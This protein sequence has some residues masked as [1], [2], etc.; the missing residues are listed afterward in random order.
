EKQLKLIDYLRN[1]VEVM[2]DIYFEG[3][4]P[5]KETF[6]KI[7]D[8]TY[9]FLFDDEDLNDKNYTPSQLKAMINFYISN[10]CT[11]NFDLITYMSS[12]NIDTRIRNVFTLISTYFEYKLPKYFRAFQN[13]FEYVNTE[14]SLGL[15]KFSLLTFL[16]QLEFGTI[17]QHEIIL[18]ESGV[19]NELVK[20]IGES[21][22]NCT[23]L[24]E[25]QEK[26]KKNSN[27]LNNLNTFE[28]RIFNKY[29]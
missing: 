8:L 27:L 20:K 16:T 23:S 14:K 11:S 19:P 12:K 6:G 10:H 2:S 26:I 25:V 15:D 22:K 3:R 28:K 24:F 1:N 7:F 18:K 17:E 13:I 21:F 9:E 29:I 4:F 5:R